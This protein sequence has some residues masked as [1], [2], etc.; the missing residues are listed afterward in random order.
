MKKALAN[1]A[2]PTLFFYSLFLLPTYLV[3]FNKYEAGLEKAGEK[4]GDWL[5]GET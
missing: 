3:L 4:L 1:I 5:R 2:F